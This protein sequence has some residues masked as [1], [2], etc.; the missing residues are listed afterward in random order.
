MLII[1]SVSKCQKNV[2]FLCDVEKVCDVFYE[3]WGQVKNVSVDNV[4]R[5]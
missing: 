2:Q 3:G 5:A 4:I 1:I